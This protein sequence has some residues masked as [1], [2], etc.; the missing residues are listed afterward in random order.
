MTTLKRV[1][2]SAIVLTKNY[3][4]RCYAL[5]L[6]CHSVM[7]SPCVFQNQIR[8]RDASVLV[9]D[10]WEVVEE[11]DFPRL[12]KLSLPSVAEPEDL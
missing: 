3:C 8:Q 5:R 10:T 11:M 2:N 6:Q 9:R 1:V 4:C 12:S 7:T